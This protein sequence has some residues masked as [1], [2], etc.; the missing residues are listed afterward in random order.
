MWTEISTQT[1]LWGPWLI[2]LLCSG[3]PPGYQTLLVGVAS[4]QSHTWS[5]RV[6]PSSHS[7]LSHPM[8]SLCPG[9]DPFYMS[10]KRSSS[11]QELSIWNSPTVPT[12]PWFGEARL[13]GR[14]EEAASGHFPCL[15][16]LVCCWVVAVVGFGVLFT[17]EPPFAPQREGKDLFQLCCCAQQLQ[18][19]CG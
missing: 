17:Q 5:C 10:P 8:N 16:L 2:L 12:G 3:E 13:E 18:P 9:P 1:C 14:A 15:S 11:I 6:C 19:E 7:L 4:F